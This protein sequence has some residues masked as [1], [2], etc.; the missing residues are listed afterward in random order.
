M[1]K[2]RIKKDSICYDEIIQQL[3]IQTG[4]IL[5]VSSDIRKLMLDSFQ[6]K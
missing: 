6:H 4:D 5:L 1:S 2:K 3:D